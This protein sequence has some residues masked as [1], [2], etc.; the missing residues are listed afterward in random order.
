MIF[1]VELSVLQCPPYNNNNSYFRK[2]CSVPFLRVLA[3]SGAFGSFAPVL[4]G[5][6]LGWLCSCHLEI[7]VS[8]ASVDLFLPD[9]M[10]SFLLTLSHFA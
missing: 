5:C 10:S 1:P 6:S 9:L 2:C 7:F 4:A 8:S 3:S